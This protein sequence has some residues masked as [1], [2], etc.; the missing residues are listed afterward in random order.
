MVTPEITQAYAAIE[1]HTNEANVIQYADR[2]FKHLSGKIKPN[3][4]LLYMVAASLANFQNYLNIGKKLNLTGLIEVSELLIDKYKYE[5]YGDIVLALKWAKQ[6]GRKFYDKISGNDIFEIMGEY[7]EWKSEQLRQTESKKVAESDAT[8]LERSNVI[9]YYD[10]LSKGE[11][12]PLKTANELLKEQAKEEH[13][14]HVAVYQHFVG[15][16]RIDPIAYEEE[17]QREL[18]ESK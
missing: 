18:S 14:K 5:T 4:I 8:T 6:S 1:K 2:T 10:K 12:T 15:N 11:S 9:K 17:L 3:G 7:L 16:K 13:R